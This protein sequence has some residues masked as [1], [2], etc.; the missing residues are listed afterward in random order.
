[1]TFGEKFKLGVSFVDLGMFVFVAVGSGGH[2]S[3]EAIMAV[4]NVAHTLNVDTKTLQKTMSEQRRTLE[5][6]RFK[7]I[8]TQPVQLAYRDHL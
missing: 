1:M 3:Y 8:L 5:G 4:R 6:L 7:A 2:G